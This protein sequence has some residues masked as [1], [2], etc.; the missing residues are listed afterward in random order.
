MGGGSGRYVPGAFSRMRQGAGAAAQSAP[1]PARNAG[2]DD[3][4]GFTTVKP[5][6]GAYRPPGAR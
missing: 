5:R 6:T 4:D 2:Q 3:T 1:P